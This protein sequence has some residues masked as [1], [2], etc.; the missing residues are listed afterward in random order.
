PANIAIGDLRVGD[1]IEVAGFPAVRSPQDG[2]VGI[3]ITRVP[4]VPAEDMS[5]RGHPTSAANP[6]I[7]IFGRTIHTDADTTYTA[8]DCGDL[9]HLTATDYF[10]GVVH[11]NVYHQITVQKEADGSLTAVAVE[12]FTNSDFC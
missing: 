7:L 1:F 3:G 8:N 6:D 12:V 11:P 5:I 9:R 2:V 4:A 10:Q